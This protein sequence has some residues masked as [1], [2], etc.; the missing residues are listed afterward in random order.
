MELYLANFYYQEVFAVKII[1]EIVLIGIKM[2][3][4]KI[5]AEPG[6][7]GI[8]LAKSLGDFLTDKF[9]DTEFNLSYNTLEE[10]DSNKPFVNKTPTGV[11]CPKHSRHTCGIDG[12]AGAVAPLDGRCGAC[13]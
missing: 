4:I 3:N 6:L 11:R 7:G 8:T 2:I 1:V 13:E 5:T 9:P 10:K 12:D